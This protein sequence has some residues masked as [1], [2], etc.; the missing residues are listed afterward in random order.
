[1]EGVILFVDDKVF[2]QK[3]EE[4]KL[5]NEL[6]KSTEYFVIPVDSIQ[7]FEVLLD[8][9]ASPVAIILDWQFDRKFAQDDNELS[10]NEGNL[11]E[12]GE[13][14]VENTLRG[15]DIYSLI[16]IYSQEGISDEIKKEFTAKFGDRIRFERKPKNQIEE[17]KKIFKGIKKLANKNK[18]LK[19][20]RNYL[21]A[22]IRT[23]NKELNF[24]DGNDT[25][26]IDY[27]AYVNKL[28][29]LEPAVGVIS[30]LNRLV[31]EKIKNDGP[32]LKAMKKQIKKDFTKEKIKKFD[33]RAVERLS[34]LV[35]NLLYSNPPKNDKLFTGDIFRLNGS[36]HIVITPECDIRHFYTNEQEKQIEIECLLIIEKEIKLENQAHLYFEFILPWENYNSKPCLACDFRRGTIFFKREALFYKNNR[37]KI[38]RVARLQPPYI[39]NL[40]DS[41]HASRSRIGTPSITPEIRAR[42]K[43]LYTDKIENQN[44]N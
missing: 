3:S 9:L 2:D 19:V 28:D 16:Y 24:L 4:H 10:Q 33:D 25:N 6:K 26:W 17:S 40:L 13:L 31:A 22:L 32:L 12:P 44:I 1:M 34:Q 39:H 14:T 15:K 21:N 42:F 30:V 41:Y 37:S 29:L 5:F 20:P 43:K 7:R 36:Y 38:T 27:F 18:A 35:K 8:S 11:I 23:M